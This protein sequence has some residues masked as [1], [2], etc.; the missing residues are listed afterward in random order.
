MPHAL[1][2]HV[3]DIR[4]RDY[5][6]ERGDREWN[7]ACA[8]AGIRSLGTNPNVA[9]V[10]GDRLVEEHGEMLGTGTQDDEFSFDAGGEATVTVGCETTDPWFSS[11]SRED[12]EHA[13]G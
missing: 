2:A 9:R 5:D 11:R 1:A 12:G 4:R 8:D 10:D 7:R 3:A 6:L 13:G